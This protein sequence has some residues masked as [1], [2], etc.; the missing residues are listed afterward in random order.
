MV[1]DI[2]IV[3]LVVSSGNNDG[4]FVKIATG[5]FEAPGNNDGSFVKITT[6]LDEGKIVS[7]FCAGLED[8]ALVAK[9]GGQGNTLGKP[10]G[11]G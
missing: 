2:E 5:L 10:L 1:G 3:G 6:G 9:S 7:I 11:D 8:G 4:S